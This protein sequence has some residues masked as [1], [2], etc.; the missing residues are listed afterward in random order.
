M[1]RPISVGSLHRLSS[2][3][4]LTISGVEAGDA[5]ET[6]ARLELK[7][8]SKNDASISDCV[9][10]FEDAHNA[11]YDVRPLE[12]ARCLQEMIKLWISNGNY[13]AAVPWSER[14]GDLYWTKYDD[15]EKAVE[16]WQNAG[17]WLKNARNMAYGPF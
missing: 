5:F 16:A 17:N 9:K 4:L 12:S 1:P 11:Y 10:S 6:A 8:L 7:E 13:R 15:L 14:L 3:L 2:P